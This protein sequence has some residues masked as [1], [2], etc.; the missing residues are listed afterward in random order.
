[1]RFKMGGIYPAILTPFTKNGKNV[2][3][4]KSCAYAHYLAD[5]GVHGIFVG[6]TSGEALLMSMDER[7]RLTEELVK[8]V[9]KRIEVVV[10]SGTIDTYSTIELTEHA[11]ASG[12]KACGIYTPS[13]YR[14]DPDALYNHY[15]MIA[16]AIPKSPILLY[17]IPSVTN[18][19]LTPNLI[20]ELANDFD[21]IVGMK[22]SSGNMG[23]LARVVAKTPK[24][25]IVINGAD[26]FTF[27]AYVTGVKGSVALT[28]NVV[29]EIFLK[30]YNE[31]KAGN[32]SAA[33]K[34]N[35]KLARVI[36]GIGS[37]SP[38]SMYKE[39]VRLRGANAGYVRPPQREATKDE[40]K[41][42][43]QALK[44]EKLIK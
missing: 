22:D 34:A 38:L 5:K 16:E 17:N 14:Y 39:A 3:Y 19:N 24:S 29:P 25:F 1:M 6:G 11:M 12:A 28:A 8:S 42:V 43:R 26:D 23:H 9:G 7:K 31:V 18:N 36:D 20:A 44:A 40:K 30:I 41:R 10:Q 21:N 37:G 2:D 32:L 13:I 33:L 27:Q 35:E 15:K 4:E